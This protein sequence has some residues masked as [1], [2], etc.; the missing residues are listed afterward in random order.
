MKQLLQNKS[1]LFLGSGYVLSV[2]IDAVVFMVAIKQVE[3]LTGSSDAYTGLYIFHYLP[4]MLFSLWIGAWIHSKRTIRV[5]LYA[6]IFFESL[7]AAFILPST[8]TLVAKIVAKHNHTEAN[9]CIKLLFVLMQMVGYGA[10]SFLISQNVT[11]I[12]VLIVS[13]L[14]LVASAVLISCVSYTNHPSASGYC[15]A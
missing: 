7:M 8:D 4:T 3:M 11:L 2:L 9:A 14:F 6:F 15:L 12:I 13:I 5:I 1:F 10:T